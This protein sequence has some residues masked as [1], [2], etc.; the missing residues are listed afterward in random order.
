MSSGP[1]GPGLLGSVPAELA[2]ELAGPE[3]PLPMAESAAVIGRLRLVELGLFAWLGTAAPSCPSAGE[4]VWA[5]AASLRAAWRASQLET[6]LPVSAGLA[7]PEAALRPGPA[8]TAAL[9]ALR[10]EGSS[11]RRA[12]VPETAAT[13]YGVLQHAYGFRLERL[14]PAADGP[15]ERVLR[16]VAADLHEEAETARGLRKPPERGA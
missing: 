11:G 14:S 15:L 4:V 10:A 6:L 1:P 9:V 16:R 8:L 2:A 7:L 5:S 3:G 12:G 13:W